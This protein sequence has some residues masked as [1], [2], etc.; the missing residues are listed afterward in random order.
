MSQS[1]ILNFVDLRK[2]RKRM[3]LYEQ[4]HLPRLERDLK[5]AMTSSTIPAIIAI[6][7]TPEPRR[8]AP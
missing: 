5:T 6:V 8:G 3:N 4:T 2:I 7:P 1:D